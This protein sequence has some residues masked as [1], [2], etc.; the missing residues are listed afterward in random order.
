MTGLRWVV[1]GGVAIGLLAAL[2]LG[3]SAI[4]SYV[5]RDELDALNSQCAAA[6]AEINQ[7]TRLKSHV[8]PS[9]QTSFMSGLSTVE[10]AVEFEFLPPTAD[11]VR[12]NADTKAMVRKHVN[13]VSRIEVGTLSTAPTQTP[14][15]KH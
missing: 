9:F 7:T 5:H 3:S 10:V 8:L 13:N 4:W 14:L 11:A 12:L 1:A 2:C 6:E 15:S